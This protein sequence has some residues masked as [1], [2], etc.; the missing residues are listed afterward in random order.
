M[1]TYVPKKAE[2]QRA[3]WLVDADGLTLGRLSTAVA[4]R[5]TGK[6]KPGY[7]PF[8]DTGD[9]VIVVNAE[10]VRL[11]GRKLQQ[12]IYRHHSGYPGGLREIPADKLQAKQPER[13]VEFAVRGMLPKSRLGKQMFRKLKVYAGSKH[14]HA[15]QK[16]QPL[17]IP[18]ASRGR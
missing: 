16:P 9:H 3:W 11:T 10:K 14:P 15:A 2:I 7:T 4:E 12:K 13:L 8:L 18:E 1:R 6:H 17:A 5:L